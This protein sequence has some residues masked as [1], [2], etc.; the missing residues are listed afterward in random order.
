MG[1][2]GKPLH[3]FKGG[4]W[5]ITEPLRSIVVVVGDPDRVRT[6]CTSLWFGIFA[7]AQEERTYCPCVLHGCEYPEG[8]PESIM[9]GDLRCRTCRS[10]FFWGLTCQVQRRR[11]WTAIP[12][13]MR[14]NPCGFALKVVDEKSGGNRHTPGSP[15]AGSAVDGLSRWCSTPAERSFPK[16]DPEEP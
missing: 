1:L 16:I 6:S 10:G 8:K 13:R 12:V 2:E 9:K 14:R 15:V 3:R 11:T 5:P 7:I 4:T